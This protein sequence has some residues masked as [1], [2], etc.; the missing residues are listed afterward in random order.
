M[1][2]TKR[3]KFGATGWHGERGGGTPAMHV[4]R[5]TSAFD[6]YMWVDTSGI[7]RFGAAE[8][9]EADGFN[10]N[11]GGS[12]LAYRE[13]PDGTAAYPGRTYSADPDT[14]AYRIGANNEGF[15]AGGTLRWDYNTT[16]M[17]LSAGYTLDWDTVSISQTDIAKIDGITNGVAAAAKAVVLD[18]SAD[19]TSGLRDV[20]MRNLVATG[21]IAATGAITG[22]GYSG[23][24]ISG[25]TGAFSSSVNIVGDFS[26][27]TNKFNVT[28]AS[29]N[30]AVAGT[31][32]VTGASTLAAL[33]ATTGA[34]SST[35]NV[36]GAFSVNTNRFTV[37]P[38]TGN[39]A[40]LGTLGVTGAVTGASYTGGAISGTTATFSGNLSIATTMFTVA[41]A[42]GNTVIAG[43]LGLTGTLTCNAISA[44]TIAGSTGTFSGNFAVNT[45][46][47]TVAA[48]TGN[49]LVAGTLDVTG[50]F[51]IATNKF[52]V[53]AAS[54]NTVIAGTFSVTGNVVSD[55]KFTDAT[56][57]IGKSGATRPRDGFYSRNV[58]IGGTLAVTGVTTLATSLAG[59]LIAT[60]G[61]VSSV[62]TGAPVVFA[63]TDGATPA[64][65]A[66][67]GT[68]ATLSASGDRTIAIPTNATAGQKLIIAH[69]ASGG[70]RT[71]ALNTGAGGF[72]F[73]TDVTALTATTSG[74]TDY[75][76]CVYNTTDSKWDVV[77]YVKGY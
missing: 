26:V 64:L 74:K 73:G 49:T 47:F 66:S 22:A 11:T 62:K 24:A 41:A 37:D 57:D 20:T 23:G 76:G 38:A 9:V 15:S 34:F 65:D 8:I 10:F 68:V 56:Y 70:A 50:D 54:G 32:G 25:T 21:T 71:L 1:T 75:I 35:V 7:V 44:T 12:T 13:G 61:V 18:A 3:P 33:A 63:L 53:T 16:R 14:G 60:A 29:G 2:A 52:N 39:T 40:V 46:K 55:L 42:N 45:N 19:V 69:S 72:R 67:L 36:V 77:A 58:A 43:T 5:D 48:A 28:A 4:F 31:L 30:T 59:T 6:W 17:K 27:A 51:A